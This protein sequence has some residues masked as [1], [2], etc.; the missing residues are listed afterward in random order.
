M[1]GYK[2]S[3]EVRF[4]V[5]EVGINVYLFQLVFR[6][7]RSDYIYIIRNQ[8]VFNKKIMLEMLHLTPTC[9]SYCKWINE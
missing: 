3:I 5:I 7:G 9:D 8:Y 1:T 4:T 2:I 6:F